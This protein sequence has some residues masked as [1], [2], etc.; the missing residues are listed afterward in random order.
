MAKDYIKLSPTWWRLNP[1]N[2]VP[3]WRQLLAR[4]I[5]GVALILNCILW[6]L[7]AILFFGAGIYLM[8]LFFL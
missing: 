4:L 1:G 5:V 6:M 2:G 7:P 8:T 3:L